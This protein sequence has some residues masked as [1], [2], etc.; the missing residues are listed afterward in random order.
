MVYYS[1]KIKNGS[2]KERQLLYTYAGEAATTRSGLCPRRS[3]SIPISVLFC[4]YYFG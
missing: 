3:P 2:V 1:Q 4:K